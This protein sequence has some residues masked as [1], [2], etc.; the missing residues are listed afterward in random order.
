MLK[1]KQ[2]DQ[3]SEVV[4]VNFKKRRFGEFL[5]TIKQLS[6]FREEEDEKSLKV[7]KKIVRNYLKTFRLN[8]KRN[9]NRRET[10]AK[11]SSY[12]EQKVR[13]VRMSITTSV[14]EKML[15]RSEPVIT[16]KYSLVRHSNLRGIFKMLR[17]NN[18]SKSLRTTIRQSK[19]SQII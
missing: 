13:Q 17:L 19:A 10:E 14:L 4:C 9:K 5:S 3:A 7:A 16:K 8:V 11:S 1:S 15:R 2:Y 18:D 6:V 12:F